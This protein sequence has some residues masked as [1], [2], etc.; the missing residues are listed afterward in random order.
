MWGDNEGRILL[1]VVTIF[2]QSQ[3]FWNKRKFIV[4]YRISG[5][6]KV[7]EFEYSIYTYLGVSIKPCKF[8]KNVGNCIKC[9]FATRVLVALNQS[10]FLRFYLRKKVCHISGGKVRKTS[11]RASYSLSLLLLPIHYLS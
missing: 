5:Y 4:K 3:T 9:I 2:L 1:I 10:S 7:G 8:V 11:I 6:I